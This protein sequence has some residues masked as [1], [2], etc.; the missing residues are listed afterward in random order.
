M[1]LLPRVDGGARCGGG[2]ADRGAGRR[3][4]GT[5]GVDLAR[6]VVDLS[7]QDG[8]ILGQVLTDSAHTGK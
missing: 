1:Y 2:R 5:D 4:G 8:Q 3:A 7:C 6:H